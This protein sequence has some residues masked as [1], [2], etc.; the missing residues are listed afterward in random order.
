MGRLGDGC[1]FGM[2]FGSGKK[3]HLQGLWILDVY[4]CFMFGG[5]LGPTFVCKTGLLLLQKLENCRT[6]NG[7]LLHA[8]TSSI[9]V[10]INQE[11]LPGY[12]AW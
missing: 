4:G 9:Y 3:I 10:Y 11:L 1:G 8:P 7:L 6:S 5:Q 12:L 2:D